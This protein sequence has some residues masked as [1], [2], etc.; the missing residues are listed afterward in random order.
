VPWP[1]EVEALQLRP[2]TPI[3][4]IARFTYH[5]ETVLETADLLLDAHH[6]DLQYVTT[7][8]PASA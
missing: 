6:Y 1:S 8:E 7:V 5:G 3:V 2:G 4:L